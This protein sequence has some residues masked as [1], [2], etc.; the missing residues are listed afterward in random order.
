MIPGLGHAARDHE[1]LG[2]EQVDDVGEADAEE[3]GR[4]VHDLGRVRIALDHGFVHRLRRYVIEITRELDKDRPG[5]GLES[6]HGAGRDGR[7]R[8]VGLQATVI[9]TVALSAG[10]VDGHMTDLGGRVGDAVVQFA[11][12]HDSATDSGAQRHPHEGVH[13]ASGAQPPLAVSGGVGV[14]VQCRRQSHSVLDQV[15][16]R[17]VSP[18]QVGCA[19]DGARLAVQGT[20][21][22]DTDPS[23]GF[24]AH[25]LG[26]HHLLHRVVDHP[27]H[28]IDDELS[29]AHDLGR[30]GTQ[31][32]GHPT[33][34]R[35]HTHVEVRAADVDSD[36]PSRFR[37]LRH[38]SKLPL[39]LAAG[40]PLVRPP[41]LE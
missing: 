34:E 5:T 6:L 23:E 22:P 4:V 38:R 13:P 8:S 16:E 41:R 31:S 35:Q 14:V 9:P 18:P 27:D 2:V 10:G 20:R 24:A 40:A 33:L 39:A 25:A 32:E 19:D 28:A 36:D 17:E 12:Q 15:T 11:A 26:V 29:A 3:L 21:R 37:H 7:P 30:L 1:D